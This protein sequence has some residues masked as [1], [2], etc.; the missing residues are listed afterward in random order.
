MRKFPCANRH[1][2]TNSDRD[3][4][5]YDRQTSGEMIT[6]RTV[7]LIAQTQMKFARNCIGLA[8]HFD[9]SMSLPDPSR[10]KRPKNGLKLVCCPRS[11]APTL[12]ALP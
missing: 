5:Y 3:Q 11:L 2:L 9:L 1:G 7:T 8:A 10:S 6:V 12:V 4:E